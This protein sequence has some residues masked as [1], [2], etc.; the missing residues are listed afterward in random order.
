MSPAPTPPPAPFDDDADASM[1]AWTRRAV[2]ALQDRTTPPTSA[3]QRI[4]R[5]IAE[6]IEALAVQDEAQPL[7]ASFE[8]RL[9][10]QW[11]SQGLLDGHPTAE[12]AEPADA[13]EAAPARRRAG[14]WRAWGGPR[15]L[16]LAA[17][18]ALATIAVLTLPW[19]GAGPADE[20]DAGAT[21]RGAESVQMVRADDPRRT[22]D[23]LEAA[24]RQDALTVRRVDLESG[25]VRV[26]AKVPPQATLAR[27][28]I[29]AAGAQVPDHGRLDL[30]ITRR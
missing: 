30:L 18:A 11:R 1:D 27:R 29:E 10:A 14:W 2:G 17:V 8:D 16:S 13:P 28:A 9:I 20:N 5:N 24:L 12:P 21:M 22:A 3:G 7:D 6:G 4:G 23:E 25:A 26:Q 15:W 19:P